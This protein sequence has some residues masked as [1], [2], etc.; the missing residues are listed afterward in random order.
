LGTAAVTFLDVGQG[1]A[2]YINIHGYQVLV[3]TGKDERVVQQLQQHMPLW[4]RS[5]DALIITHP[6][7][8]HYYGGFAV[9]EYYD[10]EAIYTIDYEKEDPAWAEFLKQAAGK[11]ELTFV[12]QPMALDIENKA[13]LKF[14]I[15]YG[16]RDI[17]YLDSNETSIVNMLMYNEQKVLLTGDMGISG[18]DELVGIYNERLESQVLKL[19]HHGSKTSSS[20]KFLNTV[21]PDI[22]IAS[23][24]RKSSYNHP[25]PVVVHRAQRLGCTVYNTFDG[26]I[27][28]DLTSGELIQK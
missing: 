4:D 28:Y 24:A 16:D 18:E 15:P 20:E 14:L 3:D 8:D 22:C 21:N 5:L 10:V 25:D 11:G 13:Q 6:D 12:R 19:G 2:M 17:S 27:T 9:L 23:A 7:R 26:A 1:D